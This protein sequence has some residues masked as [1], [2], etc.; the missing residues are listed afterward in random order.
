V[1]DAQGAHRPAE[2]GD[3]GGVGARAVAQRGIGARQAAHLAGERGLGG[4][5]AFGV[6]ERSLDGAAAQPG[7]PEARASGSG[8]GDRARRRACQTISS[9]Q[10][11]PPPASTLASV[12]QP[13]GPKPS[14]P[15]RSSWRAKSKPTTSRSHQALSASQPWITAPIHGSPRSSRAPPRV[16]PGS[17]STDSPSSR[18]GATTAVGS[19]RCQPW[20]SSHTSVQACACDW[21]TR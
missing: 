21:R 7:T 4:G 17:S 1:R 5:D 12:R 9:A 14:A 16:A 11:M 10:A 15:N 3:G 13:S 6:V 20:P 18:P 19:T 2:G 8:G